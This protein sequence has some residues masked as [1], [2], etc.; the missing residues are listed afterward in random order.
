M[1]LTI[2]TKESAT[3]KIADRDICVYKMVIRR[4]D[5]PGY[6]TPYTE[7]NIP[8]DGKMRFPTDAGCEIESR[9]RGTIDKPTHDSGIDGWGECWQVDIGF[10]SFLNRTVADETKHS[11]HD[12]KFLIIF[13]AVIPKGAKYLANDH[14]EAVSDMLDICKI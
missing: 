8:E 5:L 1:C 6:R 7:F 2:K 4:Q 14:G 3:Y 11:M 13:E 9:D 10:H 12:H